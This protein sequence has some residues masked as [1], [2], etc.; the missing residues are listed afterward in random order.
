MAPRMHMMTSHSFLRIFVFV[1]LCMY[2]LCSVP[3]NLN[4]SDLVG[5]IYFH[6]QPK[7]MISILVVRHECAHL[8]IL[9]EI[10]S[11]LHNSRG[12]NLFELYIFLALLR[13]S[14]YV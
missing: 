4:V 11:L 9:V 10:R 1:V 13:R 7:D 12:V 14:C 5:N 6:C 8:Q 2:F 3:Y